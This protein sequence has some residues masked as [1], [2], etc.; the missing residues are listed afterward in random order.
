M[1]RSSRIPLLIILLCITGALL[2]RS[3]NQPG[4]R[5][6]NG[7]MKAYYAYLPAVFIYNDLQF[8]FVEAYEHTHY[9]NEP[10]NYK[11][12]R[13]ETERGIVNKVTP[14]VALLLLPFFLIAHLLALAGLGEAD[15]YSIIYQWSVAVAVWFYLCIGLIY[16]RKLLIAFGLRHYI[17]QITLFILVLGTNLW[18]YGAY[19]TTVPHIFNFALVAMFLYHAKLAMTQQSQ[20]SLWT[21]FLLLGIL[22]IIRP[23]HLLS[24]LLFIPMAKNA[25]E[26]LYMIWKSVKHIHHHT[27][28]AAGLLAIMLIPVLIWMEQTGQPIVY[29]YGNER[30]YFDDP[31]ILEFMFSFRQGWL[32]YTPLMALS[33]G[34]MVILYRSNRFLAVYVSIFLLL[35]VYISSCWWAWWYGGC[36]GQRVMIDHYA[37]LALPMAFAIDRVILWKG[38]ILL[39]PLLVFLTLLNQFQAWQF[40]HGVLH[41]GM[42]TQAI[43]LS[44]FLSTTPTA[45]TYL[46]FLEHDVLLS[47]QM[48]V[49]NPSGSWIGTDASTSEG[50]MVNN[51]R[52]FSMTYRGALPPGTNA[53]YCRFEMKALVTIEKSTCVMDIQGSFPNYQAYQ[54]HHFAA[55]DEFKTME[56][57]CEMPEKSDS[58]TFYLWNGNTG[59]SFLVRNAE[60]RFVRL[61]GKELR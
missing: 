37:L 24:A 32:L 21:S 56:F 28:Q 55:K 13:I 27:P 17:A 14:G 44:N 59:E 20:R 60:L 48:G 22:V 43:Y 57:L 40:R 15:G 31:R 35:F 52:P 3:P 46:P 58:I 8:S 16:T 29:S 50:M 10:G 12:F 7:D 2:E 9:A 19:D 54:L 36:Y 26:A 34:G 18:Y 47:T 30:F 6:I 61:S 23:T 11:N 49:N 41:G 4:D 51:L 25:R 45:V 39:I 42:N 53:A 1:T 38:N 33:V 5:F